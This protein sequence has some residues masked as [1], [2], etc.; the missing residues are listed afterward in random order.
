MAP[1][2]EHTAHHTIPIDPALRAEI[3]AVGHRLR[4]CLT[5]I[6]R[7]ATRNDGAHQPSRSPAPNTS[8]NLAKTL[9]ID[10]IIAKKIARLTDPERT[11]ADIVAQAPKPPQLYKLA[12]HLENH[13]EALNLSHL[14]LWPLRDAIKK[15]D[16]LI[17]AS[18]G[19]KMELTRAIRTQP[20]PPSPPT[21]LP[22]SDKNAESDTDAPGA[23]TPA[24]LLLH[25]DGSVRTESGQRWGTLI[26]ANPL[27]E[28][29]R[30]EAAIDNADPGQTVAI[31]T[32]RFEPDPDHPDDTDMECA[33]RTWSSE[34]AD[35]LARTLTPLAERAAAR[36]VRVALRP[37]VGDV[38]ADPQRCESFRRRSDAR[39]LLWLVDPVA[40]LTPGMLDRARDHTA[41]ALTALGPHAAAVL[42][43]DAEPGAGGAL[44]VTGW[45][46]GRLGPA[47]LVA[48]ARREAPDARVIV[49]AADAGA[50]RAAAGRG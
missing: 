43:A 35:A 45:G 15:L 48:V 18:G 2:A 50:A 3:D 13:A 8:K 46:S 14:E 21:Q 22:H 49:R 5:E 27:T 47:A 1:N 20:S 17:D 25:G 6:V 11:A 34:G 40:M 24:L 30:I 28:P 9:K 32:G 29:G 19:S 10:Q 38:L 26:D 7:L 12:Q 41:R 42:I 44:A 39:S 33:A 37:R 23:R 31:N 16:R 36:S 4:A